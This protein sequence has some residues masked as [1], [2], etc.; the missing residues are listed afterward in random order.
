[1]NWVTIALI[2]FFAGV[3]AGLLN[4]AYTP[5]AILMEGSARRP[6][7]LPWLVFGLPSASSIILLALRYFGRGDQE[8]TAALRPMFGSP[9]RVVILALITLWITIGFYFLE[10]TRAEILDLLVKGLGFPVAILIAGWLVSDALKE[11]EIRAKYVELAITILRDPPTAENSRL[12][13][14]ASDIISIL[15]VRPLPP[16]VKSDLVSTLPIY[17]RYLISQEIQVVNESGGPIEGA[18]IRL[19]RIVAQAYTEIAQTFTGKEGKAVIRATD[20]SG[21]TLRIFI[22]K[23]GYEPYSSDIQSISS[24]IITLKQ[25]RSAAP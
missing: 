1:M 22:D 4:I 16:E 15:A 23:D 8:H 14:W 12:R 9:V 5:S 18:R 2:L 10:P 7:W 17:Q 20:A 13:A 24:M 21:A 25:L 3:V 19:M 11:K 6:W